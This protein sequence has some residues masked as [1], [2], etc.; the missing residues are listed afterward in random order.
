MCMYSELPGDPVVRIGHFHCCGIGSVSGQELRS[1]KLQD[2]TQK[3]KK[4]KV[5]ISFVKFGN[6]TSDHNCGTNQ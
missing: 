1:C 5:Y 4:K 2:M 3:K 6:V